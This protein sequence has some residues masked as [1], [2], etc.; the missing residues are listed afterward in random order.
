MEIDPLDG[1][2]IEALLATAYNARRDV[3]AAAVQLVP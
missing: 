3:I 1:P 2:A